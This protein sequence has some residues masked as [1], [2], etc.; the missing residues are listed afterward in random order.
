MKREDLQA[1]ANAKLE[2][3]LL[4]LRNERYSNAYYLAGYAVEFGLKACIAKQVR[5][6]AIPDRAFIQRVFSHQFDELINLAGLKATLE[7]KQAGDPDFDANWAIVSEWTP[8]SRYEVRDPSTVQSFLTAIADP[9]SGVLPWIKI[10][11]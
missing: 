1:M 2:D 5:A 6:E 10:H 4:L 7:E 11:W 8:D 9:A 3:A